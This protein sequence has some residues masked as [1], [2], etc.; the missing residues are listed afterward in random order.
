MEGG[1]TEAAPF[2]VN[3]CALGLG[4][5]AGPG[6][7]TGLLALGRGARRDPG[8]FP[9]A[10]CFLISTP[11]PPVPPLR[12]SGFQ[13]ELSVDQGVSQKVGVEVTGWD[14]GVGGT[15]SRRRNRWLSRSDTAL[16]ESDCELEALQ[17]FSFLFHSGV[18]E[19]WAD[20]F[21]ECGLLQAG[22]MLGTL[23]N[24]CLPS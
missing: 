14:G 13:H 12:A 6:L 22:R 17:F 20:I 24:L 19:Q 18:R 7:T 16:G 8:A 1:E 2:P 4:V 15:P 3:S 21:M 23:Q 11:P 10:R 5:P 9:V